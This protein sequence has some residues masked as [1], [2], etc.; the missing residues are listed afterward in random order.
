M[1]AN[2][3]DK[4]VHS[5]ADEVDAVSF[6]GVERG[7]GGA[8]RGQVG[9]GERPGVALR[10]LGGSERVSLGGGAGGEGNCV[11]GVVWTHGDSGG[12]DGAV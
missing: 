5:R 8:W 3:A 7:A 9:G 1:V 6:C 4:E 10:G 11:C 2:E 12:V